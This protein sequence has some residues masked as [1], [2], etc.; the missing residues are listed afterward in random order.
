MK[1]MLKRKQNLKAGGFLGVGW[2]GFGVF[3]F[4]FV[5]GLFDLVLFL[6]CTFNIKR[7]L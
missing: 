1:Y 2:L 5:G 7:N 6:N 3:S 4:E